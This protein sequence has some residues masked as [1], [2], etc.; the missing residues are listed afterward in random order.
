VTESDIIS[1]K[2]QYFYEIAITKGESVIITSLPLKDV[3]MT[4]E[5][6]PVADEDKNLFGLSEKTTRLPGYNYYYEN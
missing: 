4:I 5:A 1:K 3:D 2:D 6:L